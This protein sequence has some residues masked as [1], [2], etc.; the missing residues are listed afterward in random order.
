MPEVRR[1]ELI[2]L[3]GGA[4]AGWPVAARAQPTMPVIGLVRDTPSAPFPH[5]VNALRRGLNETGFVDGQNVR[6]EQR[7]AEGHDDRLPA[8]VADLIRQRPAVI[9]ANRPAA[10]AAK[11][12]GTTIPVV[13]ATGNDP[14]ADG[15][16]AGL[17]RPGANFTGV[18]FITSALGAKRLEL[19]HQL[20][21]DAKIIG[22]LVRPNTGETEL[23]RIDV[24]DAAQGLGLQL[25]IV[26]VTSEREFEAAFIVFLQ[27]GVG[28]L[29]V[30][31][32]PFLTSQ[33]ERILTLAA[34]HRLP[35]IGSLRELVSAGATMSYGT[36][37][38]DAYR[39]AGLY[40]GRIIKGEKPA[41]LPVMQS[42]KFEFVINLKA[43]KSLGLVIPDKLLALADEVIE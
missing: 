36:S 13:F 24:Q 26:E 4:A 38:S 3:L 22:F 14:V 28:A 35:A 31:T 16:V 5:I 39:Q 32:G 41:E 15:L 12:G 37:I 23:E 43:A 33:R 40:A 6:L 10:L 1:R 18:V 27:R 2:A 20:V 25:A 42:T 19:L 34:R 9:V 7:W 8:L 29:L 11:I 30:G 21:P 17:N